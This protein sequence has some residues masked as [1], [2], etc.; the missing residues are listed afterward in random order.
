MEEEKK[1][2]KEEE[3]KKDKVK[4]DKREEKGWK[5]ERGAT[6]MAHENSTLTRSL[7]SSSSIWASMLHNI[8]IPASERLGVHNS[9]A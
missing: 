8:I 5:G 2:W 1:K 3:T 7:S 9:Q 4:K 6:T